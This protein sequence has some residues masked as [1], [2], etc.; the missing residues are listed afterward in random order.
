V[1]VL[2]PPL[3]RALP[4]V[5]EHC[6]RDPLSTATSMPLRA[7]G[8]G[9]LSPTPLRHCC[10]S[11][12]WCVGFE[13]SCALAVAGC[14]RRAASSWAIVVLLAVMVTVTAPVVVVVVVVVVVTMMAAV[15]VGRCASLYLLPSSSG[16]QR[17]QARCGSAKGAAWFRECSALQYH[18]WCQRACV[19]L[20][21]NRAFIAEYLLDGDSD[22][23]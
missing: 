6:L 15:T 11:M 19:C 14:W 10:A 9:M 12:R 18:V 17:C 22:E 13:T 1:R 20:V 2:A 8:V 5:R 23:S 16:Q 21:P 4:T 3:V 7:R